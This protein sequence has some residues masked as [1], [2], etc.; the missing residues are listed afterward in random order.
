LLECEPNYLQ[1]TSNNLES[2]SKT[3][4]TSESLNVAEF[5]ALRAASGWLSHHD[6]GGSGCSSPSPDCASTPD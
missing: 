3:K 2:V 1:E 5:Q 4:I 6:G